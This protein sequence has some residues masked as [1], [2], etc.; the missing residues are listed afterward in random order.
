MSPLVVILII[1]AALVVLGLALFVAP[2]NNFVRL[3]NTIQESWR[4]VDVELNRRYE[5]IPNLVETVRAYAAHERN[6]LEEITRLRNQA[7]SMS[8]QSHGDTPSPQRAEVESQLTG[9]VH[10]LLVSVEAYPDLKSNQNFLELQRELVDTEDRIAAGRRFYNAN[11]RAYNTKVEQVP[12][13]IVANMFKFEKATYFEVN[14]PAVRQA[15]DVNFGEI[16]YRG[17]ADEQTRRVERPAVESG[18]EF[19]QRNDFG[20]YQAPQAQPQQQAQ[21]Q[22]QQQPQYGQQANYG[23][24]PQYGQQPN[25]GQQ[26]PQN[27]QQ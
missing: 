7:A 2:Y 22:Y 3:R 4:Q 13:N 14:D 12:S 27:P 20:G 24:Q 5:L 8:Q 15:P 9:A 19:Q 21:P 1:L 10:N 23:Q 17:P 11:V 25:Y 26:P 18:Q 6:T 16:S